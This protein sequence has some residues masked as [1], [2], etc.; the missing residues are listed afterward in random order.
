MSPNEEEGKNKEE[1]GDGDEQDAS[2]KKPFK[3][4]R[5]RVSE[6]RFSSF[7]REGEKILPGLLLRCSSGKGR[8]VLY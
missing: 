1:G 4:L 7:A 5:A 2:E 6:N 3:K 8:L